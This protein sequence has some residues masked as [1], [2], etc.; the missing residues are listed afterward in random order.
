MNTSTT[1]V[2]RPIF[3]EVKLLKTDIENRIIKLKYCHDS[4][5]ELAK[6]IPKIKQLI[7][8]LK[9]CREQGSYNPWSQE[10][11]KLDKWI[12][13]KFHPLHPLRKEI[14]H[15]IY[16]NTYGLEHAKD[17]NKKVFNKSWYYG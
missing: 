11:E 8:E 15:R 17:W 3:K 4:L 10:E 7:R 12:T 9:K 6:Q 1:N 2:L 14:D 16:L 5:Q 13:T